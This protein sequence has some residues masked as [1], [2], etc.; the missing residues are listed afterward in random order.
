MKRT[1][2]SIIAL[3]ILGIILLAGC[4]R[5]SSQQS[6]DGT[7]TT[8][9]PAAPTTTEGEEMLITLYF[10]QERDGT[11]FLVP[12]ERS[13]PAYS[14]SPIALPF[15]EE[16]IKGPEQP[17]LTSFIPSDTKVRSVNIEDAVATVDFSKEVLGANVGAPGEELGIAQIVNTLTEFSDIKKVKFLVEGKDEG[18]IDGRRVQDWWGHIGLSEQPFERREDLIQGGKVESNTII[19]ESPRAFSTIKSPFTVKGKARVFEAQFHVRVLDKNNTVLADVPVMADDFDWGN[20]NEQINY[21]KPKE[22]GRGTVLFYFEDAADGKEVTMAS[23]TV[24][25]N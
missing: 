3:L 8:K 25:L 1:T 5:Q 22:P 16:L 7:A 21:S 12:E 24:F 4:S 17:G 11:M 18:T 14:R 10:V 15:L 20:F 2:I 6:T 23:I 19:V 9:A 13:I